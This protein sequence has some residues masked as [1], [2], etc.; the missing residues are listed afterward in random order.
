MRRAGYS[1]MLAGQLPS[2][3]NPAATCPRVAFRGVIELSAIVDKSN[4]E[5]LLANSSQENSAI[6][7]ERRRQ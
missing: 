2:W 1:S 3:V 5:T 6:L 7:I 4:N